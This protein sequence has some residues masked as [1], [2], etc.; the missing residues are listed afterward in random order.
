MFGDNMQL[1]Q[2]QVKTLSKIA[3]G[4]DVFVCVPTA[5]GKSLCYELYPLVHHNIR[6]KLPE[7]QT[8]VLIVQPLVALMREQVRKLNERGLKAIYIGEDKVDMEKVKAGYYNYIF[9]APESVIRD[10]L[11]DVR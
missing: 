9:T 11:Q 3:E 7:M 10:D 4:K 1:R 2:F 5:S 6:G 8:V